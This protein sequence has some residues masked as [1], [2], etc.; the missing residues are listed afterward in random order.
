MAKFKGI[1]GMKLSGNIGGL[2]FVQ[3][4]DQTYVRRAPTRKKDSWSQKQQQHRARFKSFTGFYRSL[5][6]TVVKPIWNLSATKNLTGYNLFM[7]ANLPAFS[8]DG[9]HI[10]PALLHFSTGLLPLPRYLS[11]RRNEESPATVQVSWHTEI[12]TRMEQ[13]DDELLIAVR[14]NF[15]SFGPFET[16]CF[17]KDGNCLFDISKWESAPILSLYLFFA[18]ADRSRYSHD[19]YFAL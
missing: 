7:K 9:G 2:V 3:V 1:P 11:A 12:T 19:H 17:R 13:P 15:L 10:D 16:G 14:S 5:R 4:G 6:E 8:S 18:S